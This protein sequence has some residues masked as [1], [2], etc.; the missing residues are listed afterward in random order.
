MIQSVQVTNSNNESLIFDLKDPD[1]SGFLIRAIDGLTP[2]KA[3]IAKTDRS[4]MD[5]ATF[6]SAR[7]S[8]RNIV[9]ALSFVGNRSTEEARNE[10]YKYFPLK[11]MVK[12]RFTT[13]IKVCEIA[14]YVESN[15]A[16]IFSQTEL[17]QISIICMVP[18][19][20]IGANHRQVT[21]LSGKIP[22]FEFP[23]ENDSLTE[24]LIEMGNIGH[25]TQ[26]VLKYDGDA[27][28]GVIVYIHST[29]EVGNLTLYNL[30]SREYFRLNGDT[31]EKFTGNKIMAGDDIEISTVKGNKYVR[32]TRNGE[33]KNILNCVDR[34]SS[35]F[36]VTKGDNTIAYNTE[37]GDRNLSIRIENQVLYEGL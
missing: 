16:N 29:G 13:D 23:F 27:E 9:L 22:S 24:P 1:A 7:I 10:L 19:F 6:G 2:G 26:T 20:T 31:L 30:D 32:L 33:I 37:Y 28:T 25:Q 17:V 21:Y 5:G 8:A 35:W 18:Y 4:T 15:E 34:G 12:L 14:G 36:Q 11:K 3:N